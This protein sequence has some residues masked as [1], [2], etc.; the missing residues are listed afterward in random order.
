MG[1]IGACLVLVGEGA[2]SLLMT[3]SLEALNTFVSPAGLVGLLLVGV[4]ALAP[5][6]LL[7]WPELR[8]RLR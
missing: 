5:L 3:D 4:A 1:L 7:V 6:F 2:G 8:A